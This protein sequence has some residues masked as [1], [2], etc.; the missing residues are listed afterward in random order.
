MEPF[1]RLIKMIFLLINYQA[2]EYRLSDK[3]LRNWSKNLNQIEISTWTIDK[4]SIWAD[5]K[6]ECYKIT[7][8]SCCFF[9]FLLPWP[10]L[11]RLVKSRARLPADKDQ[12]SS[13]VFHLKYFIFISNENI[14]ISFRKPCRQRHHSICYQSNALFY[15]VFGIPALAADLITKLFHFYLFFHGQGKW[16]RKKRRLYSDISTESVERVTGAEIFYLLLVLDVR[17]NL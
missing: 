2:W 10:R 15:K 1:Q 6:I 5:Q 17:T 7:F 8:Y 12:K 4:W 9:S 3:S 16:W 13:E 14:R 11:S